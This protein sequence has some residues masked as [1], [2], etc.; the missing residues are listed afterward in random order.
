MPGRQKEK[1][2]TKNPGSA[3]LARVTLDTWPTIAGQP[4]SLADAR[5][6]GGSQKLLPSPTKSRALATPYLAEEDGAVRMAVPVE[7]VQEVVEEVDEEEERRTF[8]RACGRRPG[9]QRRRRRR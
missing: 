8:G 1:K 9:A 7:V 2:G 6:G 4:C 3:L 5:R